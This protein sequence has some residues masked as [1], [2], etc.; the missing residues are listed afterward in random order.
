MN[1]QKLTVDESVVQVMRSLPPIVRAF[2]ARKKHIPVVKQ[3]ALK[4]KLRVDQTGVLE[5]ETAFVLIGLDEPAEFMQSLVE[6]AQVSQQVAENILQ[7]INNQIFVPLRDQM[8]AAGVQVKTSPQPPVA[9]K[10]PVA[11]LHENISS[12]KPTVAT[13][14][15]S[16]PPPSVAAPRAETPPQPIPRE[17]L[18]PGLNKPGSEIQP[19]ATIPPKQI[20]PRSPATSPLPRVSVPPPPIFRPAAL[21]TPPSAPLPPKFGAPRIVETSQKKGIVKP[22]VQETVSK[23][24]NERELQATLRNVLGTADLPHLLED[25]EEP[26]PTFAP[27]VQAARPNISPPKSKVS[28]PPTPINR[29]R[30]TPPPMQKPPSIP[31]PAVPIL[32]IPKKVEPPKSVIRPEEPKTPQPPPPILPKPHHEPIDDPYREPVDE[33]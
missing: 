3:L 2:L 9:A 1:D 10:A 12:T 30:A 20:P 5:R 31:K 18:F 15:K 6:Q 17:K 14:V 22:R 33:Q 19:A 8:R 29:L 28:I 25:H 32:S 24:P 7:D 21:S 16:V 13:P 4:Y 27:R 23:K 11:P 26:S